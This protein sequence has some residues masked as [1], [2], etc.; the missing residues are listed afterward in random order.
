[1]Y[2]INNSINQKG[3]DDMDVLEMSEKEMMQKKC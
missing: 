3:D 2:Y 1:M